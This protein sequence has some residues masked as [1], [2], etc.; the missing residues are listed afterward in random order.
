MSVTPPHSLALACLRE[1]SAAELSLCC[2]CQVID[3][4]ILRPNAFTV[5][6][7]VAKVNGQAGSE[8]GCTVSDILCCTVF[9]CCGVL[10]F[11]CRSESH[12][13]A[14]AEDCRSSRSLISFCSLAHL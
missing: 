13:F 9:G 11:C 6:E 5:S 14:R 7:L 1:S 2:F 8:N 12:H 3:D 4:H 10:P